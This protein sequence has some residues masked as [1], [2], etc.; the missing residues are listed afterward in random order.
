MAPRN[1]K[2]GKLYLVEWEDAA[3]AGGWY[4]SDAEFESTL[5]ETVGWVINVDEGSV[6]LANSKNDVGQHGGL[7]LIPRSLVRKVTVLGA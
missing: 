2:L 6:L 7:W 1:M 4:R 3:S 5:C